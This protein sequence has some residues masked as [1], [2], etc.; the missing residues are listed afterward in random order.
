MPPSVQD[1]FPNPSGG[2]PYQES[3]DGARLG[4]FMILFITVL[5]FLVCVSV[6]VIYTVKNRRLGSSTVQHT[7]P[8]GHAVISVDNK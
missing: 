1:I 5:A 7:A 2:V 4:S 6:G 8:S 3:K